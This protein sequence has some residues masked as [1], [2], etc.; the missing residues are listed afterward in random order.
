MK[1]PSIPSRTAACQFIDQHG[2]DMEW[3]PELELFYVHDTQ[4]EKLHVIHMDEVTNFTLA[5]ADP[6][7]F[8]A[9]LRRTEK[10]VAKEP[11]EPKPSANA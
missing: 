5:V 7:A 10:R 2:Y 1:T 4:K 6:G 3:V 8:M 9:S 11:V